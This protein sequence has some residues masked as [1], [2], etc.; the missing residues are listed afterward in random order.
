MKHVLMAL[1]AVVL[2]GTTFGCKHNRNDDTGHGE[3]QDRIDTTTGR[4]PTH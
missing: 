4:M 1:L 2:L 3:K